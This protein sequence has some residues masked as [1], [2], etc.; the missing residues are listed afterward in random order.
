ML[1]KKEKR[2]LEITL[3][4]Y[5][6]LI[7][8]GV[9]NFSVNNLLEKISMSKG[10]FYHYFKN[11]DELFCEALKVSYQNI[12]SKIQA[13]KTPENF[14]EKLC[15]LFAIHLSTNKEAL[16]YL[17]LVNQMYYMFSN[18]KN[19]YLYTYM[20]EIYSYMFYSL[21]QIMKEEIK[22]GNL[23]E[24]VLQM[25]KPIVAT[26]DGMLTHNYMLKDYNLQEELKAYF[27]FISKQYSLN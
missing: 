26:A 21:E 6:M 12:Y 15:E 8:T 10:N 27:S 13:S 1:S 22:K 19:A 25:V 11:K 23:K 9:D 7:E 4:A 3:Q 18:E 20:Q 17:S 16:T 2:K 5:D 14:E 24:E